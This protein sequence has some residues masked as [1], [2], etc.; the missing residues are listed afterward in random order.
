VLL[1]LLLFIGDPRVRVSF[2]PL[3]VVLATDAGWALALGAAAAV[4]KRA[5]P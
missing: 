3:L 5:L 4:R 2:D 1:A